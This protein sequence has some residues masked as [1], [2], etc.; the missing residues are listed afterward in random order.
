MFGVEQVTV[1]AQPTQV[2]PAGQALPHLPQLLRSI[3]VLTQV[4]PQF[5]SPAWQLSTHVPFEQTW[6]AGHSVPHAPQLPLSVCRL[7][8]VPPQFVSPA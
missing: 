6:P 3:A 7:T 2:W 8:Q 1:Q 4:P 5:V